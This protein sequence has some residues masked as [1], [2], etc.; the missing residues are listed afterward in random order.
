ML[1]L[2]YCSPNLDFLHTVAARALRLVYID[3]GR[4]MDPSTDHFTPPVEVPASQVP[5]AEQQL[6]AL[7]DLLQHIDAPANP[8]DSEGA[9][10][11]QL[12]QVRLGIASG[13]FIA[14]RSKH[15]PTAHHCLRVALGCSAWALTMNL[16]AEERDELEVAALLHDVG[17]IGVPDDVLMKP[18]KL[19]HDEAVMIERYRGV[20]DEILRACCSSHALLEII[21]LSGAWYDGSLHGF[22]KHGSDLPLG[23]RMIAIVD[24]FD[25]MTNDDV[26]RRGLSRERAVAE[27]FQCAGTQFDPELVESYCQHLQCHDVDLSANVASHWLQQ[28]HPERANSLWQLSDNASLFQ[29]KSINDL[30]H[31]KLLESMHDGVVFVD[32]SKKIIHWNRAAERLTGISS[33]SVLERQWSPSLIQLHDENHAPI[34]DADCPLADAIDSCVQGLRR[35]TVRSRDGKRTPV[36]AQVIPVFGPGGTRYGGTLLLHDASSRTTLEER[37]QSLHLRA[38]RDPL[39]QVANRSEFDRVHSQFI[40]THLEVG[41]PYSLIICDIDH[42]KSVNDTFGHAN[43]DEALR[44]F[45]KMLKT[46]CRSGDLVARYGGEE[47]VMLC[48]DCD[49]ATATERA[50]S[51]RDIIAKTPQSAVD[52]RCLTASFGVTE[53]QSGDTEDTMLRRAD[54]AL[55]LAKERGRNR[56]VQLGSGGDSSVP[57][58]QP[59]PSSW[60]AWSAGDALPADAL[61]VELFT[62][63]PISVVQDKMKGFVSDHHATM[64]PSNDTTITVV[65]EG[66]H[67]PLQQRATDRPVSFFIQLDLQQAERLNDHCKGETAGTHI[68]ATV[69]PRNRRDRRQQETFDR[70]MTLLNSLQTYLTAEET[71]ADRR[72][73]GSDGS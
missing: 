18:G 38:T 71:P 2:T 35:L 11:N 44:Q 17:K 36:D 3:A 26:Y 41:L 46:Q 43:G 22:E 58:H 14:L 56:V 57:I 55:Y 28:L 34:T 37:V 45:S 62:P 6:S 69:Q 42:F 61:Q 51:I 27:L 59:A 32:S 8:T 29:T 13:L 49:I 5:A 48:A 60:L 4:A 15:A 31:L 47:F 10:H 12:I 16:A 70:A 20:G 50:D 72:V 63:V 23:A 24:A 52:G 7:S 73:F 21:Q 67:T 65:I 40:S 54:R 39:T 64:E 19:T 1:G 33:K 68:L 25:S 53:L 66:P 9:R 30:Y